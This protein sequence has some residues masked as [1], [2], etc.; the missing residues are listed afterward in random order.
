GAWGSIGRELNYDAYYLAGSGYDFKYRGQSG[1]GAARLSLGNRWNSEAG[2]EGGLSV[3]GG[4]RLSM[5]N[6]VVRTQR[7]GIDGRYRRAVA[8][9]LLTWTTELGGGRDAPDA[10]FM[11]LH[12]AEYLHSSRRWGAATQYRR[13][14]RDG[15]GYDGSLLAEATLYF[16]NDV[17]S[18]N[19][20]WI[21]VNVE[22]KLE[23]MGGRRDVIVA[24][25]Y[26]RY[27]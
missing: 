7:V 9:G 5:D 22:R 12:Q 11:Q 16:S 3:L 14:W 6:Q 8:R 19:L 26:Y 24:L 15:A 4:E 27:W 2:L 1:L 23:R 10:V 20:H 25:Q 17:A 18:S 21:K 13:Y